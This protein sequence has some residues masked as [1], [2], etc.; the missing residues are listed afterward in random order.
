MIG[1]PRSVTGLKMPMILS[2]AYS[3]IFL[4]CAVPL[5]LIWFWPLAAQQ[6]T[7]VLRPPFVLPGEVELREGVAYAS[8]GGEQLHLDIF[9]PRTRS[10]L[11]P[12][13]LY[14]PG[15]GGGRRT[16]QFWRQAAHLAD[17]GYVGVVVEYRQTPD[18]GWV[19]F[20]ESL[21][22]AR[23]ALEWVCR[24]AAQFDIDSQRIGLVGAS[25]GGWLA[26]ILAVFELEPAVSD[27]PQR[28]GIVSVA[29]FNPI[30]DLTDPFL[31]GNAGSR[32][33][34]QVVVG[35]RYTDEP[36]LWRRA[37]PIS[38]MRA[39]N[40]AFLFL[41]GTD[42]SAAPY[43]QSVAAA[44]KLLEH[45]VRAEIFTAGHAGHGFFNEPPWYE[46]TLASLDDF[47]ERTLQRPGAAFNVRSE[48]YDNLVAPEP[49]PDGRRIVFVSD[50]DGDANIF[51]ANI[52]GSNP[53]R[54]TTDPA[55][56]NA[57][58]WA[59][60]GRQILFDSNRDG[61]LNV[62]LM[63]ADGS[64]QRP[65]TGASSGANGGGSWSPQGSEIV[66]ASD[67]D[68][69]R[70]LYIVN[71][72]GTG[73][74]RLTNNSHFDSSPTWSP[75]G[76]KIA[77]V[78][79]RDGSHDVFVMEADGSNQINLTQRPG[80]DSKPA[81]SPDARQIAFLSNRGGKVDIYVMKADGT[82]V[83]QL[84]DTIEGEGRP[85]WS[86]DGTSIYFGFDGRIFVVHLASGMVTEIPIGWP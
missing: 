66:F 50:R 86:P 59:P 84:T 43:W 82:D 57:P 23:I 6:T 83:R 26:A 70:E 51:V 68:G 42:D 20:P 75:D 62:F 78:S 71:A 41:H 4:F 58:E 15:F 76:R 72:D 9:L 29:L 16:E 53:V 31:R 34:P 73:A 32:N 25:Q 1:D 44:T 69:N 33:F 7:R 5:A 39:G 80:W 63:A 81:W 18:K 61:R 19:Q 22:D 40:P 24:H 2:A 77:F 55:A 85:T 36:E 52:D 79:D 12:A 46:P 74:R 21:Q 10:G 14:F 37:S 65:L 13:I 67:R 11:R 35:P 60:D 48:A 17:R 3:R 56:D 45:R 49:S 30:L 54:L 27:C 28:V 64:G 38:H 8:P 47:F